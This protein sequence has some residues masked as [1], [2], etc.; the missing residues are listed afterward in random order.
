MARL[1]AV[2]VPIPRI[3][4]VAALIGELIAGELVS[5]SNAGKTAEAWSDAQIAENFG[6]LHGRDPNGWPDSKFQ[7]RVQVGLH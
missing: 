3:Y 6:S 4:R 7:S 5:R 1:G 2:D